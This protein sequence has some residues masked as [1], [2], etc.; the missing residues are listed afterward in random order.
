MMQ[1][2]KVFFKDRI[3][4]LSDR[5]DNKLIT[6]L[7]AIHKY[8][9][10]N[11]LKQFVLDF[12]QNSSL[13]M[14]LIYGPQLS[15]VLKAFK[16]CFKTLV[17]AGGVVLNNKGE[18]LGIHRLGCNDLPKGKIE[19]GENIEDGALREVR[20]ECGIRH[21]KIHSEITQTYHTYWLNKE[22]ILKETHWFLMQHTGNE[23]LVP[24]TEEDI[25]DVFWF[26]RGDLESFLQNT[27]PSIQEVFKRVELR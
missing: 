12:E 23:Q 8:S 18:L 6:S 26:P 21:L 10:N 13:Q 3:L 7:S 22:L 17:A 5:V 2:Y 14:G 19:P 11:Q 1:M 16:T 15:D 9:T 25:T 24:Q 27:Y 4:F 20:E